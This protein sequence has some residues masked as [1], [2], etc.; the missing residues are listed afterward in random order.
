[1]ST[2]TPKPGEIARNWHLLLAMV[3]GVLVGTFLGTR[4]LRRIPERLF[5]TTVSALI[6]ALG[7]L[8][9]IQGTGAL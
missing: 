7:I 3:A 5:R 2:Y 1:M 8:L 6:L 9:A 4:A